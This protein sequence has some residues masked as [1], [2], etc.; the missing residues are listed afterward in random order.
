MPRTNVQKLTRPSS[1]SPKRPVDV[2]GAQPR[3][4]EL[5]WPRTKFHLN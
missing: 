5:F 1:S 4:F 3:Y 2:K